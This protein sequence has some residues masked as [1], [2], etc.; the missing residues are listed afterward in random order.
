MGF[1]SHHARPNS[2]MHIVNSWQKTPAPVDLGIVTV[3]LRP[4]EKER[5]QH[6]AKTKRS[7]KGVRGEVNFLQ[8]V[9]IFAGFLQRRR[10]F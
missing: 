6:Q 9:D 5:R 4:N 8:G 10:Q 2:V 3:D 7:Y 1:D